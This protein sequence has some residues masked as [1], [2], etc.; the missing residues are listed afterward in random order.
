MTASPAVTQEAREVARRFID[1]FNHRELDMLR[2]LITDDT[3]LRRLTG[4]RLRGQDGLRTLLATAD[5]LGL[6]LVPFRPATAER[7]DDAVRVRLPVRELIGPDD[8]ERVVE[9]D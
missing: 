9:I 3:E 6:E 1:A 8:I 2:E 4:E 5:E 7:H